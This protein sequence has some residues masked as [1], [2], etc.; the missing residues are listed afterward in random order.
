[1][2]Q[3]RYFLTAEKLF[4][5]VGYD[6]ERFDSDI[7]TWTDMRPGISDWLFHLETDVEEIDEATARAS[8]PTAFT[9]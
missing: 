6:E 5:K 7:V 1:M 4:R 3:A 9:D 8:F 2:T